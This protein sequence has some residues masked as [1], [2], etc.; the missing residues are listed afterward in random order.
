MPFLLALDIACL[1]LSLALYA[2]LLLL[3]GGA[4]LRR[5][6]NRSF[7]ALAAAQSG[8]IATYLLLHLALYF[9]TGNPETALRTA[10][11]FFGLAGPFLFLFCAR[12]VRIR[13]AWP[14]ALTA[15]LL[16]LVLTQVGPLFDGRL[17]TGPALQPDGLL[18]YR[19]SPLG[20]ALKIGYAASLLA[21]LILLLA[22][23]HREG[24]RF[25][26]LSVA[27]QLAGDVVGSIVQTHLPV[28]AVTSTVSVLVLGWGIIRRQLFNP[29]RDLTS[30]LRERA[31]RQELISQISRRTATL[32]E[33]DELLGQAATLIQA[34]F[35]YFTVAVFLTE[36]SDLVLRASTHPA[37]PHYLRRFKLKVGV[38]GICGWVAAAGV[39][40]LVNDVNREPR[41][42]SLL[43]SEKTLSELAV[44]ILRSD[45]V[46]GVLDVQ[47]SRRE[48]FSEKDMLTQQTIADQLSNAIENARLYE[49][50][51]MRAERLATVNRISAAASS[52]LNLDDLLQT[53]YREV[54]PIFEAD[55][56]FIAL[57]DAR[58]ETLDFRLQMD[59][60]TREPAFRERLGPGLTSR[61][62]TS[63]KPLLVNNASQIAAAGL[64]PRTWGTGKM[65]SSWLGV[66]MLFGERLTGV[67]SVQTYRAH[68]YDTED[69]LLAATIAE[70]I[71]VAVE[72]ARL[73][74][75]VRQELDVRLRTEKVLRESEEKFRNLAEQS[76]NMIFIHG[77]GRV[78]YA[79]R[80]CEITM[81][82]SREELYSAA[83]GFAA[84]VAPHYRGLL[85]ASLPDRA[86]DEDAPPDELVLVNR[87]GRRIDAIL[88]SKVISFE[89]TPAI[90][91]IITDI[92]ARK[93]TERLLQSLN[94]AT[95]AMEQALTPAEVFPSAARVLA[96]LGFDSAVYMADSPRSLRA[97]C[98]GSGASAEVRVLDGPD[99]EGLLLSYDAV[100]EVAQALD[101]RGALFSTL[102]PAA[103]SR[104]V[105]HEQSPGRAGPHGVILAPLAADDALFGLLVV[106]SEDLGPEDLQIFTA[107]AHQASA[108]W[109]K[110]RLMRDLESSVL[111]LSQTQE[112]LL[113]SQKMEAIGRLAGGI[114][115]DFNNLLTVISGYTSLLADNL[116]GNAPALSDLGQIRNTIK[117][118]SALTSRLLTFSRKQILQPEVLDLNKLVASSV[119]LLQP[120]IG[121][122][123]ELIVRLSSAALWVRAD[124]GQMDQILMNLAVNAR[125]A[126]PGGGKL[127]L[128][129]SSVEASPREKPSAGESEGAGESGFPAGLA[130]GGWAVLKVQDD[131][132][133][134]SE[135]TR[136]HI[137]EPF[138]T[139]K[140]EG[141]GSGL[142]LTTVYGI[143]TQVGG[144][145]R[146]ESAPG[147][148]SSFIVSL[149]RV[150]SGSERAS[151]D[152]RPRKVR[153]GSG[154]I[155]L[156]ED[157]ADVR[158]LTRRVLERGG[159]MV[160]PVTSAR[161]ALLAAEGS[162]A[163]DLVVTDVVMP[164]GMSGVEM[165]E[166]LSRTRPR[167]PVLYISGYTDDARFRSPG[168]SRNAL[169][170]LGKP[171]QPEELLAKV[172][173]MVKKR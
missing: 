126:M 30:A 162:A 15:A 149:P 107:F 49:E 14:L 13:G 129:T 3:V 113:H 98:K 51:R 79:N 75:E 169:A 139:T 124:P 91:G 22:A 43:D 110:T 32:L 26:A 17:V 133:G 167:L 120:L 52:V 114:A 166:R 172:N 9:D 137:F 40:L 35:E 37:A 135:E 55:A 152:E 80:Q 89:G 123:I 127:L 58:T 29:L 27:L 42:V 122:D 165:G 18:Q 61:V 121:E 100:P 153:A 102:E 146:V 57:Y 84:F 125:D 103:V 158:D 151:V 21:S 5:Q 77:G 112:Q 105:A 68:Q 48:A 81:G 85:S 82:Y 19:T 117:R 67:L 54:A 36:G 157:E 118:A 69:V 90:L 144:R 119:S 4:G 50:T 56:L 45:K 92:S 44:P 59:E 7:I 132:V 10:S 88:T 131:G 31:H 94:A 28:L 76:P 83:D 145:V 161:E 74:E 109:R 164:G 47:S 136:T 66:P 65:P 134:M 78:L 148:G 160:I 104:L 12:C 24:T 108:A 60:G 138:F 64:K 25:L 2:G 20:L 93:R 106:A 39:P 46:I 53:V 141:K 101:S 63:R 130:P 168:D 147:R 86:S 150:S 71:A 72:N 38:E 155:L 11:L 142:G 16:V 143:V 97:H 170:F 6:V 171:F 87:D 8:W 96:S 70:Q 115:H 140:A 34:S 33:L 23:P 73:Y 156:V 163:L 99:T 41:Y 62:V 116:E 111:K 173:E 159:Y 95:L 154:T 1:S 128:E